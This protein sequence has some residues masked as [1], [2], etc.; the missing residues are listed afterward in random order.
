MRS[1][2]L[3]QDDTS[4]Y[5]GLSFSD[6]FSSAASALTSPVDLSLSPLVIG[7]VGL[8][9]LAMLVTV[10]QKTGRAVARKSR[11]VRKALRA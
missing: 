3:G 10:T 4:D 9:A 6:P 7:G 11:A 5:S 8:L 2:G 1:A